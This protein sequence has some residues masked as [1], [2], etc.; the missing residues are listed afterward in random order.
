MLL[1]GKA[2]V[3][4]IFLLEMRFLSCTTTTLTPFAAVSLITPHLLSIHNVL[5]QRLQ[6]CVFSTRSLYQLIKCTPSRDQGIKR[7]WRCIQICHANTIPPSDA[8]T[9]QW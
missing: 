5:D 9:S 2:P 6:E 3:L 4:H 8:Q 7:K 1:H